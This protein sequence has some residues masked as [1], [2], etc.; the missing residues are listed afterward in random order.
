MILQNAFWRTVGAEAECLTQ[1]QN[2]CS[3]FYL[4]PC[5]PKDDHGNDSQVQSLRKCLQKI[6]SDGLVDFKLGGH[7]AERP[8]QVFN[9]HSEDMFLE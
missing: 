4:V 2:Q 5:A 9:G 1:T 3:F 8:G 6:E 7:D